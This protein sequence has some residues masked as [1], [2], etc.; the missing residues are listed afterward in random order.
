MDDLTV[1]RGLKICFAGSGDFGLP[2]L[3]RLVDAGCDVLSVFSQPDKPAGRG[4]KLT[5]TPIAKFA[6]ERGL[7]LVR[8]ADIN[9]EPLPTCDV[10][11]VIAFGQKISERVVTTPKFGAVNLHA[12]RLPKY[13]GAAP[14]HW[15]VIN[16]DPTS[17]N[18]VIRLAEKMDAGAVLGM[19]EVN[20]PPTMTTGELYEVLSND[21]AVLL[22][23]VLTQLASGTSVAVEQDH[24]QATRA[25]KLSREMSAIDFSR[26]A[27]SIADQIRGMFPW[28]GCQVRLM[29]GEAEI[30]RVTLVRARATDAGEAAMPGSIDA[31][32]LVSTGNGSLE[33]LEMQPQGKKPMVLNAFRNG[34]PW[35]AGMRLESIAGS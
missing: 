4:A 3:A 13:R 25:V 31:N 33:I 29:Q 34:K 10:L 16:G 27:R 1:L 20:I 7:S 19:S 2:T 12:S 24:T 23:R 14:I 30:A 9:A 28:P 32:G 8:T 18:S 21:G 17:G 5:P 6:I 26:D 22:P 11:V 15:A 35:E